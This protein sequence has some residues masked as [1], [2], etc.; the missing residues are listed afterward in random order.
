MLLVSGDC[1]TNPRGGENFSLFV[2]WVAISWLPFTFD[3][4]HEYAK[5]SFHELIQ[6]V[7]F[8][9]SLTDLI[10]RHQTN[11]TKIILEGLLSQYFDQLVP[12]LKHFS[13]YKKFRKFVLRCNNLFRI[14]TIPGCHYITLNTIRICQKSSSDPNLISS[15]YLSMH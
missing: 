2:F 15:H 11:W 5:W 13:C 1:D 6:H 3:L 10:A 4:I 7:W 9:K 8:K 14:D 12:S